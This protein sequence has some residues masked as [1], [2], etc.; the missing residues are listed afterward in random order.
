MEKH[1]SATINIHLLSESSIFTIFN[2]TESKAI[3]YEEINRNRFAGIHGVI[4][5]FV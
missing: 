5:Q 3:S 2:Q 4:V 1:S